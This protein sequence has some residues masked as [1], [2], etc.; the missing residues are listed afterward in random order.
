[1]RSSDVVWTCTCGSRGERDKFRAR[2]GAWDMVMSVVLESYRWVTDID[3]SWGASR[4]RWRSTEADAL[5]M[6]VTR[7]EDAYLWRHL[8]LL[9]SFIHWYYQEI[10]SGNMILQVYK[11]KKYH[12]SILHAVAQNQ[13]PNEDQR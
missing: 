13:Q 5:P 10:D 1:M 4:P 2:C 11:N 6:H 12:T 3:E 7:V 9:M 8:F